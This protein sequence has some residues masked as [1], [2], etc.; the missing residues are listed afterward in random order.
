MPAAVL[1]AAA[2][3]L[4]DAAAFQKKASAAAVEA[5]RATADKRKRGDADVPVVRAPPDEPV[6]ACA[7]DA[8][9]LGFA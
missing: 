1:H 4:K 2:A 9:V 8:C 5:G 3:K 7:R 6:R